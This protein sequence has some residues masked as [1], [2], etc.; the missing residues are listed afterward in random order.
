MICK[1]I[2]GTMCLHLFTLK[3]ILFCFKEL[4]D[5]L[6]SQSTTFFSQTYQYIQTPPLKPCHYETN[7]AGISERIC[8]KKRNKLFKLKSLKKIIIC[9]GKV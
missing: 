8:N 9:V 3:K 4:S 1:H 6:N 2:R 7:T 5:F